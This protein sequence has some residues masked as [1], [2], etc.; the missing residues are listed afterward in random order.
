MYLWAGLMA[1]FISGTV[2]SL[3]LEGN[4]PLL[5]TTT[6]IDI[7]REARA[8][9]VKSVA[10]WPT[11]GSFYIDSEE[12]VYE[13]IIQ[14][15][16]IG[17][18]QCI[19]LYTEGGLPLSGDFNDIEAPC[20]R[21]P[22]SPNGR[23]QNRTFE[24]AHASGAIVVSQTLGLI[25]AASSFDLPEVNGFRDAIAFGVATITGIARAIPKMIM[26]DYSFLEGNGFWIKLFLLYPL[27]FF[28]VM[29][30]VQLLRK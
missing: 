6:T 13:S 2:F 3:M 5:S 14:A 8:I 7:P 9:P 18:I 12:V 28:T 1:V 30:L 17:D 4:D 24:V 22:A 15:G 25:G 10:G 29:S 21:V 19:Q 16:A 27:S 23:G 26:W 20:F 11:S